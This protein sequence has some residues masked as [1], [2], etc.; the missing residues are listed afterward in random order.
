[1]NNIFLLISNLLIN[2]LLILKILWNRYQ[3]QNLFLFHFLLNLHL[4][5]FLKIL[6]PI[7]F[8]FY[9]KNLLLDNLQ[10]YN[11]HHFLKT[12][13]LKFLHLYLN[14]PLYFFFIIK[15]ILPHQQQLNHL[16][17]FFLL[18]LYILKNVLLF[19]FYLLMNLF[20]IFNNKTNYLT[21]QIHLDFYKDL[22]N[23]LLFQHIY[24]III[25]LFPLKIH[26]TF[27]FFYSK[28]QIIQK[29]HYVLL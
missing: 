28:I 24:L 25:L 15:F 10:H 17:Q 4:F 13:L 20:F 7:V 11:Q 23:L 12:I 19:L 22:S 1:M 26:I 2:F 29:L 18:L 27:H 21:F 9:Y 6:L 5:L 8:Y 3:N 16:I 14:H